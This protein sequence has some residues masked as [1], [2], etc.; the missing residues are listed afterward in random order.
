MRKTNLRINEIFFS[1]QGES[2]NVG[3]PTIFIRLTGCPLR[4]RYCDTKY[5]FNNGEY[6][7]LA[8]ILTEIK[9]Y[10]TPYVTVTGGE[11]LAQTACFDLLT[12]LCDQNYEVQLETSGALDISQVDKR[13]TVILDVKTPSSLE[14]QKNLYQNFDYLKRQDQIK[15][16]LTDHKDF[17]WSKNMMQHH[18]LA[19]KCEILFSPVHGELDNQNLADWILTENLPVRFQVQLHKYIWG[20]LPGK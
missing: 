6:F 12:I 9:Q 17:D 14:D 1:L 10:K 4:C 7:T 15:F 11:P 16:V 13:V 2:A 5:S 20:N 3:L 8:D 18:D 19:N